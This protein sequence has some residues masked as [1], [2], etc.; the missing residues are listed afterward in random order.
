MIFTNLKENFEI[1]ESRLDKLR[2]FLEENPQ[3]PFLHYAIASELLKLGDNDGALAGFEG[4]L[5]DFPDYVGTYY[6][7]GKLYEELGDF[8]KATVTYQQGMQVAQKVG[9][10]NTL[11]ELRA[12]LMLIADDEE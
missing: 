2:A 8:E 6:H 5:R 12:A 4:M 10:R 3:D 7:L 1:M 9:D 11:N